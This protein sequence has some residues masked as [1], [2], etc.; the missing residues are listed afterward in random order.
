M[1]AREDFG[2]A[3]RK[4]NFAAAARAWATNDIDRDAGVEMF[5]SKLKAS[6][7]D[8]DY[9]V[10]ETLTMAEGEY[11]Y[12]GN[13]GTDGNRIAFLPSTGSLNHVTYL[14]DHDELLGFLEGKGTTLTDVETVIAF[15]S[16]SERQAF[17]QLQ[18]QDAAQ[19]QHAPAAPAAALPT[20][21]PHVQALSPADALRAIVGHMGGTEELAEAVVDVASRDFIN[22]RVHVGTIVAFGHAPYMH[23]VKNPRNF[24]VTLGSLNQQEETIW[25]KELDAALA[26]D[27]LSVGA[28]IVLSHQGA[29]TVMVQVPERDSSGALTGKKIDAPAQ[30]NSWKAMPF[31]KLHEMAVEQIE[32]RVAER[33]R[34]GG[35]ERTQYALPVADFRK[36]LQN[37]TWFYDDI[38]DEAARATGQQSLS[39]LREDFKA[40]MVDYPE[41]AA[42]VWRAEAPA[43]YQPELSD[44]LAQLENSAPDVIKAHQDHERDEERQQ[45]GSGVDQEQDAIQPATA[46]AT[47]DEVQKTEDSIQQVTVGRSDVMFVKDGNDAISRAGIDPDSISKI[48]KATQVTTPESV[49]GQEDAASSSSPK[50]LLNGRFV[51]RDQGQYF[52]VADGLESTRVALVDEVNKIRFVDKQMDAFQAAIELAKHKQWEAILV[53]GSEKFRAEAWHHARMAGLEVVGYEPTEKDLATLNAAQEAK[54]KVLHGKGVEVQEVKPVDAEM[55]KSLKAARDY[56]LDEGYGVT[57]PKAENG[58]HV[59][60]VIHETDKH[61]VQDVGRKVAVVH[62]KESFDRQALRAAMEKGKP[63]KVQYEGGRATIEGGKD[64]VQEHGR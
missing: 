31:E 27:D 50:T 60:K 8:R 34:D 32:S 10:G 37:A 33:E 3:L 64:R 13:N 39:Q 12:L 47:R 48:D 54:A 61:I 26:E 42:E 28:T 21:P 63:L 24:Y 5:E 49:Q 4:G 35:T 17:E 22:S 51:L 57:E 19:V 15:Y 18:Q 7:E 53:T 11:T 45:E 62:A 36:R 38:E 43:E 25:G 20:N 30:R 56:A 1:S 59:G 55:S 2:Q 23:D 46:A 44:L 52:R 14:R 9:V 29:K 41:E 16:L 6:L 58:R 40:L